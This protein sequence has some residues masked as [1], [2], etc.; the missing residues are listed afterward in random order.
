MNDTDKDHRIQKPFLNM[1][2]A[3]QYDSGFV[4][5][6]VRPGLHQ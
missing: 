5:D 2:A 6:A 3:S 1:S 4:L